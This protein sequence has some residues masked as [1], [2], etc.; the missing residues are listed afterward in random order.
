MTPAERRGS[1]IAMTT[2]APLHFFWFRRD[3]RLKD[4]AG[5]A[6]ALDAGQS[7]QPL[8]IF[9][10]DIL[11]KLE[12]PADARVHF[13]HET[14]QG[15]K[16]ELESFGSDLWVFHGRPLEVWKQL[17]RDYQILRVDAN[18]DYE[19][20]AI[21][22]DEGVQEF[23]L[24]VGAELVLTKDQCLFDQDEILT[25]SGTQYTVYTPYKK[26]V[27]ETLKSKPLPRF[28]SEGK[29]ASYHQVKPKPMMS[30]GDIGFQKSQIMWP[31]R[32]IFKKIIET[33]DKTRDFPALEQGTSRLGLHLRFGTLSVRELARVAQE[34]NETYLS[35]LIWRDFF[36]QILWRF[37]HVEKQSFRP[38]YDRI[39]WRSSKTDFERWASGQTGYPWIDAGMRE[40]NETGYMHNR[41]RMAVASFLSKHLLIHWY[42]GERYFA[43]KLLDYDLSANNGNW[44]W[45]AGTGCD[46]APY[47]RVFNPESQAKKFDPDGKYVRRWVPE[48]ETSKYPEPMVEHVEARQRALHEYSAALKGAKT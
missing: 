35:E 2:K 16:S 10:P 34:L 17:S 41:V 18:R 33:Y 12:D 5:L 3:L 44:Q 42:E 29:K 45:A 46:A 38:D 25:G 48:V 9:D 39:R 47:F 7:V 15:L 20:Q 32:K 26:K 30:L 37:P 40:L 8:F 6:K 22:R 43:K 31:D 11:E 21:P 1:F 28:A 19:P 13:I 27:L 14:L 24:S 36:M 4:N 23:L